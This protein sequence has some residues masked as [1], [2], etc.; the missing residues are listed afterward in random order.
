MGSKIS[1]LLVLFFEFFLK[2]CLEKHEMYALEEA[3]ILL[4]TKNTTRVALN[5][6][7]LEERYHSWVVKIRLGSAYYSIHRHCSYTP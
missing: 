1:V 3:S 5:D 7:R 6:Y 2:A 4:K